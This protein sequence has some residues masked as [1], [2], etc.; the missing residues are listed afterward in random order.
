MKH[1]GWSIHEQKA[2]NAGGNCYESPWIAERA[3]SCV[4]KSFSETAWTTANT[5]SKR[6]QP[7]NKHLKEQLR[8]FS[9]STFL[10]PIAVERF[11]L[12][13]CFKSGSR[14][15]VPG[16]ALSGCSAGFGWW[17]AWGQWRTQKIFMGGFHSVAYGGY[18]FLVCGL[19]DV[20]SWRYIHVSKPTFWRSLLT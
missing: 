18:L 17:G 9:S 11:E 15:I 12:L 4:G 1:S 6:W 3:A 10:W 14:L 19:C 8:G 5:W 7:W 20:T 16:F 13:V 2:V